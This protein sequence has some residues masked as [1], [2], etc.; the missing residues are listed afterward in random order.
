V[1]RGVNSPEAEVSGDEGRWIAL[2]RSFAGGDPQIAE[3]RR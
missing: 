2:R 1:R 3:M